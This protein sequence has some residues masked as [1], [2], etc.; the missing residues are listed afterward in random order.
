M[1]NSDNEKVFIIVGQ[2]SECFS[3]AMNHVKCWQAVQSEKG[4][5]DLRIVKKDNYTLL[6]EQEIYQMLKNNKIVTIFE[7]VKDI[8]LTKQGKRKYIINEL[9][10]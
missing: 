4:K 5:I 3:E 8:P 1:L 7:Y 6:D 2:L 10:G 9:R